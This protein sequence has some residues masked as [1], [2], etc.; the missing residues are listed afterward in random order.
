VF[1]WGALQGSAAAA[2][3][4]TPRERKLSDATRAR[5]ASVGVS[6]GSAERISDPP[7]D[8]GFAFYETLRQVRVKFAQNHPKQ[9][10][11]LAS[12]LLAGN[13]DN[14]AALIH[15]VFADLGNGYGSYDGELADKLLAEYPLR[16]DSLHWAAHVAMARNEI[17]R[18]EALLDA[19]VEVG[20]VEPEVIYDLACTHA[21]RGDKAGA[22]EKLRAAVD[23]GYRDFR[24]IE[25][26]QDLN[27]I[28]SDPGYAEILRSHGR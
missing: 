23:A 3:P 21:L 8:G 26:D 17:P 27:S 10:L 7:A 22:V 24:N 15:R 11:D 14:F 19:A 6:L 28:R 9:A 18:A 25:T 16:P 12:D 2:R 1:P 4:A 5:L 13:P 20:P